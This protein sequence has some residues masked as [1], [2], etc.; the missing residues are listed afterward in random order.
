MYVSTY[1]LTICVCCPPT[2]VRSTGD[3]SKITLNTRNVFIEITATDYNKV[4][5]CTLEFIEMTIGQ[6]WDFL[7]FGGFLCVFCQLPD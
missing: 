5:S 2:Y 6:I 4:R 1:V 3:H 7:G